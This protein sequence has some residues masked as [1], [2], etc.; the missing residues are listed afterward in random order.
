MR[1]LMLVILAL[2]ASGETWGQQPV[3]R[4]EVTPASVIVGEP[5]EL[6]V[7][8]LVPTWFTRP[9]V[10]PTFELANAM[11]RLPSDSS[12]TIRERVGSESWS[13]IVR[14]YEIYP[15]L[16]A[17]YRIAGQPITVTYANPGADPVS[18]DIEVPEVVLRGIVP[19]GAESLDPYLAGQSLELGIDV[20]G[21]L[22]SLKAGGA[23]VLTYRADLDGLPAIFLPPLAPDLEFEG[24]SVYKDM[25]DVEDGDTARRSEKVTL[26]F[27]AGGEFNIPGIGLSFWN[28]E[29]QSIETVMADGLVVSVEG[30]P[31]AAAAADDA[32]ENS[33]QRIAGA[34]AVALAL[35]LILWRAVPALVRYYREAAERRRR[36]EEYAFRQLL[37][38]LG[39][40]DSAAAYRA[41]LRWAGKLEPGMDARRFSA[42][43]GD[44][45][46][47][48]AIDALS[49][50]IYGD[51]GSTG[52]LRQLAKK[53]KVARRQYLR[54]ESAASAMPLPPLNP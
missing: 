34:A 10:Y 13:G 5:A 1:R 53:L 19:E 39:S 6:T 32:V 15:L 17:T 49:A 38:A 18:V 25:P 27:E 54:K 50:G 36:T 12:Y 31:A 46:L 3:V 16:G 7:T 21:E 26:V 11:T 29:S 52:N 14:T 23:I 28:T 35:A 40:D 48:T 22:D 33:W 45:S 41:L 2:A 43:Y 20:E 24:V 47:S 9:L 42:H 44:E 37:G 4:A 51:A 8:V 30:P